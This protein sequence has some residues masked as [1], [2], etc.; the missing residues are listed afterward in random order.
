MLQSLKGKELSN[1]A[2]SNMSLNKRSQMKTV[3]SYAKAA[4]IASYSQI[5]SK[6]ALCQRAGRMGSCESVAD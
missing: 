3:M 5:L 4:D 1:F 6:L 2:N